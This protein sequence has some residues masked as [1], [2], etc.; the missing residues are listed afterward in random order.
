MEQELDSLFTGLII[1]VGND[2]PARRSNFLSKSVAAYVLVREAGA[3]VQEA[4]L[5]VVDGGG[6]HGL[7]AVYVAVNDVLWLVQAKY[8]TSGRGEPDLGD[9]SKGPLF[10]SKISKRI[11]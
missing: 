10:K 1:G 2:A 7:D 8:I 6:D 4:A 3:T 9:V 11:Q 5:A